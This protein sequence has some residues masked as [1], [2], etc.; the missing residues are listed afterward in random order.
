MNKK[1]FEGVG[2]N[3]CDYED[4]SIV[5]DKVEF[6]GREKENGW[7]GIENMMA[8]TLGKRLNEDD[9]YRFKITVEAELI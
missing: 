5:Y 1:V 7:L 2:H 6:N 3:Y 4:D 8:E 9:K